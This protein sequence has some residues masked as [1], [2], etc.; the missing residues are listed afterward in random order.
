MSWNNIFLKKD[1]F[2]IKNSIN[3]DD[4]FQEKIIFLDKR[5]FNVLQ[6]KWLKLNNKKNPQCVYKITNQII[7]DYSEIIVMDD[8]GN[9]KFINDAFDKNKYL[10]ILNTILMVVVNWNY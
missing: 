2:A 10:N 1:C 6:L 9:L 8:I 5:K 3:N 4:D 7:K